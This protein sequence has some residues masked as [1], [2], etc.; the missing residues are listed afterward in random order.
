MLGLLLSAQFGLLFV[1]FFF[2]AAAA[3]AEDFTSANRLVLQVVPC[4]FAFVAA[5][6]RDTP[7]PQVC[8]QA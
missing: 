7:R 5:L 6:L 4:V 2:T 1:L 3:W 8:E